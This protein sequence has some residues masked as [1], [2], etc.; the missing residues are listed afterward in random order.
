MQPIASPVQ[1]IPQAQ[2]TA[3]PPGGGQPPR[4]VQAPAAGMQEAGRGG[5]ADAMMAQM[6]P[7]QQD[8]MRQKQLT[9]SP[10][11]WGEYLTALTQNW[12]QMGSDANTDMS[13]ADALRQGAPTS[14]GEAGGV[15][16]S[17]NPLEHIAQ[18]MNN[19]KRETEYDTAKTARGAAREGGQQVRQ[20]AADN[21]AQ[22][23]PELIRGLR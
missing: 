20:R 15:Y 10:E 19:K 7:E 16:V 3:L 22:S 4:A 8:Q 17:S 13:R 2:M 14:G 18:V 1:P 6:T 11:K 12:T 23:R 5:P 21:Y 9:M